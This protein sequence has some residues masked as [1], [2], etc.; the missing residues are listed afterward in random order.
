VAKTQTQVK[1]VLDSGREDQHAR[2]RARVPQ[3][4]DN[5]VAAA[6]LTVAD[7]ELLARLPNI[8]L[9]DL[10][11]PPDR[12]RERPRRRCKQRPHLAEVV[13]DDRLARTAAQ[14]LKQLTDPDPR[15]R[16]ILAQ[17][18][19]DLLLELIQHRPRR[20]PPIDRRPLAP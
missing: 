3:A 7:R 16:R 8:E 15:K 2:A 9:A 17:Q 12:P 13:I 1:Q 20:R 19:M 5:D 11:G 6:N 4:R 14:R 10:S 18:P